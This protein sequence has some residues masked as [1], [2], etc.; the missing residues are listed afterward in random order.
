MGPEMQRVSAYILALLLLAAAVGG[1]AGAQCILANPSF[2]LPGSNGNIFGGWYQFGPVGSSAAATHGAVA[3]RASG[4]N[5]VDW[6]V[7]GFW[8][9]FD[10]D[11]GEQWSASVVGWHGGSKPLT[12]GSQAILNI[13]WRNP[14]GNLI[15]YESHMVANASTPTDQAVEFSVVSGPAPTGTDKTRI[16]LGVLQDPAEPAPDAYF[17]QA[18]FYSLGPPTQ[19]ELQWNDFPGGRTVDFSGYS[20]RVKGPG[21][22]G[23]GP[24]LFCD[25]GDCVWIDVDGRL[26]MTIQEISGS[27]YSTE[28]ALQPSLGYGDYIFTTMG[29]LDALDLNAVFGLFL[30]EYGRCWDN[31]YLWW[32][33]YN[34]IDVEFSYWD[35]PTNDIGQFVAQPYDYVGNISR[36]DASFGVDELTSHAFLW[37][38]DRVEFRSWRGGPQDEAPENMI[39]SWTYTGPH[40]PRPEQPRVH[41]NLWQVNGPP[42]VD[43]EVVIDEFTFIPE[44][45]STDAQQPVSDMAGHLAVARPNPFNACATI[46]YT[47]QKG[48]MTEIIVYDVSGRHVRTLVNSFVPA[49]IHEVVW[50]GRNDMGVRVAS[51][52]Y[53]YRLRAG[54]VLETRKMI[55]LR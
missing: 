35:N 18:T 43:Q 53:F 10:C 15:D 55:L 24:S 52:L 5:A 30:W 8:Q 9:E 37:L 51:G 23:P 2:E 7:S 48:G 39:H 1:G 11:P 33:P 4:P 14:S 13:E 32:N 47:I 45:V 29:Q 6:D 36:F 42:S 31:G 22:Y 19:D 3:A 50:D 28:V 49:G 34:E 38:S 46:E 41:I 16:L 27:W 26:H 25:T 12:G 44:G 21:Y 17:D 40:I 54:D 20:W